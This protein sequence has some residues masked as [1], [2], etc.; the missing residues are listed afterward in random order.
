MILASLLVFLL[1][2][3]KAFC[4]DTGEEGDAYQEINEGIGNV[5]AWGTSLFKPS[6]WG[7]FAYG[8]SKMATETMQACGACVRSNEDPNINCQQALE[9][10][11]RTIALSVFGAHAYNNGVL[12]RE[13]D[14]SHGWYHAVE[15]LLDGDSIR[16]FLSDFISFVWDRIHLVPH[17]FY[18]IVNWILSLTSRFMRELVELVSFLLVT[19]KAT[20]H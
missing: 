18:T 11:A 9:W 13:G 12:K 14:P 3:H 16:A 6:F 4:D 19:L 15:K 8:A 17:L 20:L 5:A 7:A 1:I 10:T 2:P